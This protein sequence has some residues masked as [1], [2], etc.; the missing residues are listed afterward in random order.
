MGST[1]KGIQSLTALPSL[2]R[3]QCRRVDAASGTLRQAVRSRS[4]LRFRMTP[5]PLGLLPSVIEGLEPVQSG[6][7]FDPVV[8]GITMLAADT[9][10]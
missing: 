4:G 5:A 10:Q 6:V 8:S 2:R 3:R 9:P 1:C 7:E